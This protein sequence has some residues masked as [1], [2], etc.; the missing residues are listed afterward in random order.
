[1]QLSRIARVHPL[2]LVT[3]A[4]AAFGPAARAN[5]VQDGG[6]ETPAATGGYNTGYLLFTPTQ[7]FGTGNVWTVVG[8]TSP[9][10]VAVYNSAQTEGNPSSPTP[11]N[12]EE[13]SQ[14]LDLTGATDN[15]AQTGV[16]QSIATDVGSMY[17][18]SFYVGNY[19]S[20]TVGVLVYLNGSLFQTVSDT[21]ATT[22]Y[23][24]TWQQYTYNFT[25]TGTTTYARV[26]Q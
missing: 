19:Q 10:N 2:A 5:L 4:L 14:A 15:G 21:D 9:T 13:G 26:L 11:L 1:M 12:V 6:F 8:L 16:Q 20:Q 18:L 22:G 3:L 17:S 25:A 24:T 7:T 23:V